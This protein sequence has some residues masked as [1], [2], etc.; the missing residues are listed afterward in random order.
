MKVS[1]AG[2]IDKMDVNELKND[3]NSITK[4]LSE[5]V[6]NNNIKPNNKNSN[7]DKNH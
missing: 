7:H 5:L 2:D 4:Q 6:V 1:I 3:I